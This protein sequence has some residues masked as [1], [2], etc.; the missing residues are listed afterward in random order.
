MNGDGVGDLIL[1]APYAGPDPDWKKNK[2]KA[3]IIWG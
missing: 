1:G 3:Y 2:G